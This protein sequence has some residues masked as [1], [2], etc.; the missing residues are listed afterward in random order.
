MPSA[1]GDPDESSGGRRSAPLRHRFDRD[2]PRRHLRRTL[3]RTPAARQHRVRPLHRLR[4]GEAILR[5]PVPRHTGSACGTA[6]LRP[7]A[8]PDAGIPGVH[9]LLSAPQRGP[10]H[11]DR[12]RSR[13]PH[14]TACPAPGG[15][16]AP[17]LRLLHHQLRRGE[18]PRHE[19]PGNHHPPARSAHGQHGVQRR[20]SRGTSHRR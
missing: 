2:R 20:L 16:A 8:A 11:P 14:R 4:H 18:P 7:A 13:L 19:L 17:L 6:L 10:E 9:A 15:E 5:Q 1:A 12:R 3:R